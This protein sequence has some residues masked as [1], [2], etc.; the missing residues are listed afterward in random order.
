MSYKDD[1]IINYLGIIPA[2]SG[3]TGIK[4]KNIIKINNKE[5][6]RYTLEPSIESKI[7]K[8][9]FSTDSSEYLK[10]YKKYCDK[11]KDV[12]FDYLRSSDISQKLSPATEYMHDCIRFLELQGYKILNFIILQPTSLFRTHTQMNSVIEQH[13][14]NPLL[15]IKSVSPTTQTPYYMMYENKEMVI[16]HSFKNRQEHRKTF[17]S[18]GAYLCMSLKNFKNNEENFQMF[19]MSALDGMDMDEKDDLLIIRLLIESYLK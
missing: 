7:D 14:K 8:I 2:R 16:K 17:I 10:L 4:N 12:T 15:N 18:N 13:K 3:S 11:N 19:Y 9:F 1:K 5:C 6:F